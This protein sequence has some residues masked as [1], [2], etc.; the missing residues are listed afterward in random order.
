[1]SPEE[2]SFLLVVIKGLEQ[3]VQNSPTT[4]FH[5]L[6]NIFIYQAK[7]QTFGSLACWRKNTPEKIL[8]VLRQAVYS[9]C[10]EDK[11]LRDAGVS[12]ERE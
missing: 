12:P 6:I 5:S 10:G 7:C 11:A 9:T 8:P 1:M 4:S 3:H 2:H